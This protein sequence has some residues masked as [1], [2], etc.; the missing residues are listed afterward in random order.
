V[1][2]RELITL[3]GGAAVAWPLAARAQQPMPVIGFLSSVTA[4]SLIRHVA[5][6]REG[7]NE[8]GFVEGQNVAI[9][10]RWAD[11]QYDRLPALAAELV[12]RPVTVIVAS[13][14]NVV[15]LAIK[16]S[17]ATIPVVFTALADPVKDGLVVSFN[18]PGGNVTGIAALTVEL[19]PK[20]LELLRELVPNAGLIGALLNPNRPDGGAQLRGMQSAAQSVAQELIIL[21]AGSERELELAFAT[22][23]QKRGGALLVG[24]DPLFNSLRDKLV[25][26]AAHY[27]IP[28]IYQFRELVL[29]GGL[30]SY[31]ANLPDAYRQA[32]IYVGRILK[33]EK[34]A[35]L[36]VQQPTKFELVINLKTARMLGLTVPPTLLAR[37]DEVIE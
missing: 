4:G 21:N 11:N 30:I 3:L 19:D 2:R 14:G 18:R 26:L 29:A 22:L 16:A 8:T 25:S 34:P 32:G 31:G 36:P 10:Y 9:E 15:A 24:A 7:L 37:A 33:G 6:F 28:A 12:R 17:T 13:G 5:S 20:R 23:A 27:A 1:K 35:D